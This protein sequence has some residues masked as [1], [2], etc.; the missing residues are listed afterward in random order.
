MAKFTFL[1]ISIHLLLDIFVE[2]F[3]PP[4]GVPLLFPITDFTFNFPIFPT[5][6][7]ESLRDVFSVKNLKP[8]IVE[9]LIFSPFVY[10][11]VNDWK[12]KQKD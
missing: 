7:K 1:A 10:F 8:I 2:D 4:Y 5:F 12:S 6:Y 11:V 3:K 9:L